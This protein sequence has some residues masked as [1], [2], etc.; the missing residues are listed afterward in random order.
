[1]WSTT[2]KEDSTK[3]KHLNWMPF[4]I[5]LNFEYNAHMKFME[6]LSRIYSATADSFS[7][8]KQQVL[9]FAHNVPESRLKEVY[10]LF[11]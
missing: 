7:D 5:S 8:K 11:F 10:I 3:S 4:L 9:V 6:Y 1:M 2:P